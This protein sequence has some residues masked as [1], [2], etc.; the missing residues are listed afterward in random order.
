MLR[1]DTHQGVHSHGGILRPR[2]GRELVR[3][4]HQ[5]TAVSRPRTCPP[6]SAGAYRPKWWCFPYG[7]LRKGALCRPAERSESEVERSRAGSGLTGAEDGAKGNRLPDKRNERQQA[8]REIRPRR[9]GGGGVRIT[10]V[11]PFFGL[12]VA[13]VVFASGHGTRSRSLR[14]ANMP[15]HTQPRRY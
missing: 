7:M 2:Y 13:G 6:C 1:K 14:R 11:L 5:R 9:S 4:T 12:G 8:C 10:T 15:S 3:L